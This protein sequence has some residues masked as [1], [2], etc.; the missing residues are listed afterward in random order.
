[1]HMCVYMHM[2]KHT[3][4]PAIVSPSAWWMEGTQEMVAI[5]INYIIHLII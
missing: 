5:P 4:V 1:M 2:Y 3:D